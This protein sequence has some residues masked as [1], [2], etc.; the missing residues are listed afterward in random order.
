MYRLDCP[1]EEFENAMYG[2]LSSI[3]NRAFASYSGTWNLIDKKPTA[4]ASNKPIGIQNFH[5]S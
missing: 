3:I 2:L 5:H 1:T 4:A